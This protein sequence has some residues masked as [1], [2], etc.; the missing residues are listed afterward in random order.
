MKTHLALECF[1]FPQDQPFLFRIPWNRLS[2]DPR[3]HRS[4]IGYPEVFQ[5]LDDSI[6]V[7]KPAY[8][9]ARIQVVLRF[10][11]SPPLTSSLLFQQVSNTLPTIFMWLAWLYDPSRS[12]SLFICIGWNSRFNYCFWVQHLMGNMALFPGVTSQVI[13]VHVFFNTVILLISWTISM[14]L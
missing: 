11:F 8:Y 10:L 13:I 4:E 12:K 7:F 14:Y 5:T 9:L 3:I 6:P 2:P 1:S